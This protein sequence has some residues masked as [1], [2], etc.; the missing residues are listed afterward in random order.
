MSLSE[1][2]Q[3][4]VLERLRGSNPFAGQTIST[5]ATGFQAWRNNVRG[6]FIHSFRSSNEA[7]L[8]RAQRMAQH[9]PLSAAG[10]YIWDSAMSLF[11]ASTSA[12]DA[13]LQPVLPPDQYDNVAV[14]LRGMREQNVLGIDMNPDNAGRRAFVANVVMTGV[15][16]RAFPTFGSGARAAEMAE[17]R[18]AYYEAFD[19]AEPLVIG[20]MGDTAVGAELG[21]RRLNSP[22]WTP[23]VNDAW[24]QGGIDAGKP[25]YLGSNISIGN[26]RSGDRQFPTT[27]FF[28]ELRQLR[29]AA[30]HREE[31]WMLPPGR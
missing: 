10:G 9:D 11:G 29:D 12:V 30:Y 8:E 17:V 26:L 6:S 7:N 19:S 5:G 18:A 2:Y 21:M 15:T 31:V 27:I 28:R 4:P 16:W 22:N 14:Q 23:R 24:V 20:R 3:I 25:F 1:Y 13:G